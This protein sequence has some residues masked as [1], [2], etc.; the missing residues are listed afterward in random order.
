MEFVEFKKTLKEGKY[1]GVYVFE[2][3]DAFFLERGVNSLKEVFVKDGA[4]DFAAFNGEEDIE[5]ILSSLDSVSFFGTRLTVVRE[6]YPKDNT[7]KRLSPYLS[8]KHEGSVFAIVNGKDFPAF[9]KY[10]AV[11]TVNC[12]KADRGI[13]VRWIKAECRNHDVAIEDPAAY[14]I[15]TFC[16]SDMSKVEL[17]T[18]KLISYVGKGGTIGKKEVSEI[19]NKDVEYKIYKL[20][21]YIG[22]KERDLA[23][24]AVNE[25]LGTGE[26]PHRIISFVYAHFRRLLFVAI[27]TASDEELVEQ[28]KL[29]AS[30]AFLVGTARKQAK[31]FKKKALKQAVDLLQDV[32]FKIKSGK[33]DANSALDYTVLKLMS[34]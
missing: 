6:F 13:I 22:N 8:G 2:G 1:Y 30:Q 21:E 18:H 34:I 10:P 28:L 25:M 12:G 32:D 20:A 27:S 16:L 24:S 26:L 33:L 7:L 14:D 11:L 19:V 4:L 17:E 5:K 29:K 23:L 31:L 15:C 3:E 9:K